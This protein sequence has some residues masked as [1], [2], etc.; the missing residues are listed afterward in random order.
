MF[1]T[2]ETLAATFGHYA[3]NPQRIESFYKFRYDLFV[4]T[5]G[6]KLDVTGNREIEAPRR[7]EWVGQVFLGGRFAA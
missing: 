1:D 3:D 7:I 2:A 5:L 6:W 4:Q